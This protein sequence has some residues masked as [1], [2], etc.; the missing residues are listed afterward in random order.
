MYLG[1][2]GFLVID[3]DE[4]SIFLKLVDL[5]L[6]SGYGTNQLAN[7]LNENSIPTKTS[8]VFKNGYTLKK[9]VSNRKRTTHKT[10]NE[11]NPGTINSMFKNELYYGKR[12]FKIGEGTY[13]YVDCD[14]IIDKNTFDKIQKLR[15]TNAIMKK[16]EDKYF[17]LLKDLL[18]C[19]CG[20]PL[21]G[22]I[23]PNRGEYTYRCNTKRE[24]GSK[25]NSRGINIT[26][27][28][29]IVWNAFKSSVFYHKIINQKILVQLNDKNGLTKQIDDLQNELS[30]IQK[31]EI[32][33]EMKLKKFLKKELDTRIPKKVYDETLMEFNNESKILADN[34]LACISNIKMVSQQL[35]E[36]KGVETELSK[37]LALFKNS[38]EEIDSIYTLEAKKEIDLYKPCEKKKTARKY[39][40]EFISN[41]IVSY[42]PEVRKHIIEVN[43]NKVG[44]KKDFADKEPYAFKEIKPEKIEVGADERVKTS[45]IELPVVSSEYFLNNDENFRKKYE[46]ERLK[47]IKVN[48]SKGSKP[49]SPFHVQQNLSLY[50]QRGYGLKL[51]VG[52]QTGKN[53]G[54]LLNVSIV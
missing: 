8:K 35:N 36:K 25:C 23:K 50:M 52:L 6:N 53:N 42:K 14:P 26:K 41:I 18:I 4:K 24:A 30:V 31:E 39:I 5:Y 44:I 32:K 1:I 20:A 7:W 16:K 17:Y 28:N 2:H 37:G 11:W 33:L 40:K 10:D 9:G 22:R 49:H 34:K 12:K 48:D 15:T 47:S 19:Q 45:K 54:E 51:L 38:K 13:E 43:F 21:H 46:A 27:L 3:E 29:N